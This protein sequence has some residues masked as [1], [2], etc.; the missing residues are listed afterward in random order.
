MRTLKNRLL[1]TAAAI[2]AVSGGI[3][4]QPEL[5]ATD[6]QT[7]LVE[8]IAKLRAEGGPTPAGLIDPLR[9]LAL[10]YQSAGDH[11]LAIVAL[12]EARHV[13][14]VHHGLSSADEA[15]LL[16]EQ[17][18]SEKV[19]GDH[20]RVWDVEQDMVTIARQH[21][22]DIRM[23]PI[24]R[25]MAEDRSE[26]LARVTVGER[27]PMINIGCYYS[28]EPRRYDDT[29][30]KHGPDDG[31]HSGGSGTIRSNLATEAQL[32]YADAIEVMIESGDYA[33]QE[34][35]DLEKQALRA[36]AASAEQSAYHRFLRNAAS[37]HYCLSR[38][39]R[40]PVWALDELLELEIRGT[41]LAPVMHSGQFADANVGRFGLVRLI[42]YEMRS[43]SPAAARANAIAELADWLLANTP[44][45]RLRYE[46]SDEGAL[47]LYD[48]VYRE[49]E[50][51]DE[52]R[53]SILSPEVPITLPTYEPN[54]FA[55]AATESSHYIDVSF[56]VTKYG[57]AERIEIRDT[58]KSAN[59]AEER[60]LIR[61][62]R[63]TR[64]RPRFVDGKLA[65]AAPVVVRY[66]LSR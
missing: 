60:E 43:G 61:L 49:L 18:R 26:V 51:E 27:P 65:D 4:A 50:E 47:A 12:E 62:I 52:A 8:Q 1:V 11:A 25:E 2:A 48:R 34:L 35:R 56:E 15:L 14:R 21:H 46:E 5:A 6:A 37:T 24:F 17:L 42:A 41:C 3:S 45:D 29:R 31:C 38:G 30:G 66:H 36:S 53:A 40:I 20:Q 64:F 44:P 9:D 57:L 22:G 63:R 16:R 33:S 58:S 10:F 59:R 13:T 7:Q 39:R 28:G 19:L 55:S 54:S 23:M 32:Y